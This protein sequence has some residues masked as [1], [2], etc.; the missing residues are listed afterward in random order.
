MKSLFII[1]ALFLFVSCGSNETENKSD[2]PENDNSTSENDSTVIEVGKDDIIDD[3]VV[4]TVMEAKTVKTES[5][6]KIGNIEIQNEDLGEMRWEDAKETCENL[7]GGWRLPTKDE[8]DLLYENKNKIGGFALSDYWSSTEVDNDN[9]WLQNFTDG[10]QYSFIKTVTYN[11]RAVR[12][13]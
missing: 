12:A 6:V 2:E 11:V 3:E 13:F 9:V 7:G 1:P 10:V 4:E 5:L 8:L